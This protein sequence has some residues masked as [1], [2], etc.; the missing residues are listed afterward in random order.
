MH[1]RAHCTY[2]METN[3]KR[4]LGFV[5]SGL[6]VTAC[7][8]E[9]ISSFNDA[10]K[11]ETTDDTTRDAP[12]TRRYDPRLWKESSNRAE[13][14]TYA[15]AFAQFNNHF[16]LDTKDGCYALGSKPVQLMLVIVHHDGEQY[17]TIEQTFSDVENDKAD[18]FKKTYSGIPT[19]VPPFY[20]FVLQLEMD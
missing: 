10:E 13:Y 16:H 12:T 14:Q 9:T 19:K 2:R 4:A 20:P 3:M 7:G 17:A 5:L 1:D 15:K 11:A 6:C 8:A 18:C